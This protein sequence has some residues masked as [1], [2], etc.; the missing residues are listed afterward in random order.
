MILSIVIISL[1]PILS[2]FGNMV[3]TLFLFKDC[4][5]LSVCFVENQ[6]RLVLYVWGKWFSYK[7]IRAAEIDS[8]VAW[9]KFCW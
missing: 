2:I 4:T 6:L 8:G 5:P 3:I 7:L 9:G 1:T